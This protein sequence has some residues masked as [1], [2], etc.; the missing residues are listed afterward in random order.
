MKNEYSRFKGLLTYDEE[1]EK[2]FFGRYAEIVELV[3]KIRNNH[4]T[5]LY[6]QS[7]TGKSSLLRAGIIP[8]LEKIKEFDESKYYPIRV[9]LNPK[10][11]INYEKQIAASIIENIKKGKKDNLLRKEIEG[12][13][14][15]LDYLLSVFKKNIIPVIILDQFEE[16]YYDAGLLS[17]VEKKNDLLACLNELLLK[18]NNAFFSF[19]LVLSFREDYLSYIEDDTTIMPSLNLNRYRLQ[20]FTLEDGVNIIKSILVAVEPSVVD[21]GECDEICQ[22]MVSRLCRIDDYE[23]HRNDKLDIMALSLYGFLIDELRKKEKSDKFSM[24]L[25]KRENPEELINKYYQES[26]DKVSDACRDFIEDELIEENHRKRGVVKGLDSYIVEDLEF[27]K[28]KGILRKPNPDVAEYEISHD[29]IVN[30]IQNEKIKRL[31]RQV[32]WSD[33]IN[34]FPFFFVLAF[35]T[36][37]LFNAILSDVALLYNGEKYEIEKNIYINKFITDWR[38][39]PITHIVGNVLLLLMSFTIPATANL[40]LKYK[41]G[42]KFILY[43]AGIVLSTTL[44]FY[45]WHKPYYINY[46]YV[47][48]HS[49][50]S[51]ILLLWHVLFVVI[52]SVNTIFLLLSIVRFNHRE[53]C[54]WADIF[55]L[56]PLIK[57]PATKAYLII[58]LFICLI[59]S[60]KPQFFNAGVTSAASI[61][62]V[63]LIGIIAYS[64]F[65]P[66]NKI[67]KFTLFFTLLCGILFVT[68]LYK[69]GQCWIRVKG[70]DIGIL[71]HSN[72]LI[73]LIIIGYIYYLYSQIKRK[74]PVEAN[75]IYKIIANSAVVITAIIIYI[76]YIPL[77]DGLTTVA[78]RKWKWTITKFANNYAINIQNDP[79]PLSQLEFE[80]GLVIEIKSDSLFYK[81]MIDNFYMKNL[82]LPSPFNDGIIV[83][84]KIY[85]SKDSCARYDIQVNPNHLYWPHVYDYEK[86]SD[87]LCVLATKAFDMTLYEVLSCM[88]N[89]MPLS[90]NSVMELKKLLLEEQKTNDILCDTIVNRN[91]SITTSELSDYIVSMTKELSTALLI[92]T[93][94]S[95]SFLTTRY[96]LSSFYFTHF[97]NNIDNDPSADFRVEQTI[98]IQAID[99]RKM[100]QEFASF[101]VQKLADTQL[102]HSYNLF[103]SVKG[104]ALLFLLP[105]YYEPLEQMRGLVYSM[106]NNKKDIPDLSANDLSTEVLNIFSENNYHY[107]TLV[108]SILKK[109]DQIDK[110][111]SCYRDGDATIEV[112]RSVL[113]SM[114]VDLISLLLYSRDE[115]VP[116][117][118]VIKSLKSLK[119]ET[120]IEDSIKYALPLKHAELQEKLIDIAKVTNK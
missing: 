37:F 61:I 99:E 59:S 98:Q 120:E 75:V 46:H 26:I 28:N 56:R 97:C 39:F 108:M 80:D 87:S 51:T 10:A 76:G 106:K 50:M 66:N 22:Y 85:K 8:T 38:C 101:N 14:V 112:Y 63:L 72:V 31:S 55:T 52:V 58:I 119:E 49:N 109:Y 82:S 16:V 27:L 33:Y 92:E 95:H 60:V 18:N 47:F 11:P 20:T 91:G 12:N 7:G 77:N 84:F 57:I 21:G 36:Y 24:D 81:N 103:R 41:T 67:T 74:N 9:C 48:H 32:V 35:L 62:F 102:P 107:A 114:R 3:E 25:I 64:L 34:L 53:N 113:N 1:D 43:C 69:I 54:S 15:G 40:Y 115:K 93:L 44:L 6:G 78:V 83:P 105:T 68:D 5:I 23:K 73:I 104:N 86:D 94:N 118:K 29:K 13:D 19:R 71:L 2:S 70:V 30:V 89:N 111:Q 90:N 42:R 88:K 96:A 100:F 79:A 116:Y 4:L 65:Y 17:A 45:F 110:I 117:E